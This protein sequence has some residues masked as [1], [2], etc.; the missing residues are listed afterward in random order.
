MLYSKYRSPCCGR[1]QELV[2]SRDGGFVTQNCIGCGRPRYVGIGELPV[3][4]C[5]ICGLAMQAGTRNRNYHYEC[6]CCDNGFPLWTRLS[7][8]SERF[9]ECGIAV[10]SELG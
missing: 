7:R 5:D 1:A 3:I 10:P 2:I 8:W 9:A 4:E 6:P